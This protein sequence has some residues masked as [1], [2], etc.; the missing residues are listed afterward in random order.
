M[1]TTT[2]ITT[3]ISILNPATGEVLQQVPT[4]SVASIQSKFEKARKAQP[5]W[6]NVPLEKKLQIIKNFRELLISRKDSLAET[7]TREIGKPI[8]QARNELHGLI[9]RIDFF[10]EATPKVLKDSVVFQTEG[11]LEEKISHEPL[12]VILNISA[13]NYP[14]FVGANVWIPALLAGN[15][16]LYKPSEFSTLTGLRVQ[17]LFQEAGVPADV[18]AAVIGTGDIGAELLKLPVQGV[19]FTGSYATGKKILETVGPRMIRV[20]L[21]LGGKDPVYVREDADPV[22]VAAATADGAFYNA[23]QSCCSVERIYVQEKIYSKFVEAFVQTVKSFVVGDPLDPQT[24]LGPITREAH[25]SFLEQQVADARQKGATLLLGGQR[26]KRPGFYF[27]PTVFT[28]VNH[29]MSLMREETFGPLI[30]IQKVQNDE[31][32]IQLM[33]DT[34]YGLTSSVYTQD[35]SKVE[36]ILSQMNSGTVY[37][38]CCD[39]ISPKLPWSGRNHSGIGTTL[40]TYGVESFL[41][42][43]A[44]H[45]QT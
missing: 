25:L 19:F 37:W 4:D 15:S 3:K 44:W 24:Y 9:G 30:G 40:S 34:P 32:A 6:A 8:S 2:D 33:N 14:Y 26:I 41:Q 17:E 5:H 20:Q 42:L 11:Q 38:N 16:V 12:G 39:R 29:T 45:L 28:D 21:E 22:A 23:G 13:W 36:Q 27:E 35:R 18:F 31:E 1:N 43:K 7:L 10:L